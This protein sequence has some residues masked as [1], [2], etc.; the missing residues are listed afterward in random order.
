MRSPLARDTRGR[1]IEVAAQ[2]SEMPAEL[3]LM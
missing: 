3:L 1:H 2:L